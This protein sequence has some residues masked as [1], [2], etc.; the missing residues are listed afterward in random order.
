MADKSKKKK[1]KPLAKKKAVKKKAVKK[2][3]SAVKK[4]KEVGV[5]NEYY[6]LTKKVGDTPK[7]TVVVVLE[8][9][10]EEGPAR[11]AVAQPLDLRGHVFEAGTSDLSEKTVSEKEAK[12][13]RGLYEKIRNTAMAQIDPLTVKQGTVFPVPRP[14]GLNAYYEV[15]GV[16]ES[17]DI[18]KDDVCEIAYR[19]DLHPLLMD[20][21]KKPGEKAEVNLKEVYLLLI[22]ADNAIRSEKIGDTAKPDVASS[23]REIVEMDDAVKDFFSVET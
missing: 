15:K 19:R 8:S 23:D 11:V 1:K 5:P 17:T 14:N 22:N 12:K 13:I 18:E 9:D 6:K 2:T 16:H 21:P 20:P 10:E 7:G 4:K 3:K